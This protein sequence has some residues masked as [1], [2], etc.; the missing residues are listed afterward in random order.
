MELCALCASVLK[1]YY[2][3]VLSLFFST[4]RYRVPEVHRDLLFQDLLQF[5][6][7]FLTPDITR[8]DLAVWI[9]Q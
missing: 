3:G 9:D 5:Y 8:N 7:Q 4:Q 1:K 2:L 6:L